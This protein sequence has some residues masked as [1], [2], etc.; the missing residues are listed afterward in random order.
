VATS[1]AA[2]CVAQAFRPAI[3]IVSLL[4]CLTL[5]AAARQGTGSVSE[6]TLAKLE[7]ALTAEP[8]S[9]KWASEYRQ[10]IIKS[11]QYDRGI[12]FFETLTADHPDAP[13]AWLNYGFAYVDKIPAAGSITQVILANTALSHFTKSLE[14]RPSW[15]GYYT[16]GNSYLYW[17]KI[18]MRTHLGIADLEEAQAMQRAEKKRPYHVRTFIALGDGY[19][20]MDEVEKARAT[21]TAGLA[22][23]PDNAAL[24]TRLAR[25]PDELQALLDEVFDP[26]K[27]VDTNL[28]ELW[29]NP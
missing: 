27:R 4:L 24:K 18:F 26:A 22:Q 25:T 3:A 23:F 29:A 15:I 7:T 17:P 14:L 19:F 21:W 6:E 9:L 11:G 12:K 16:R 20:K 1:A 5:P 13:N 8:D 10:A 28:Q 2:R